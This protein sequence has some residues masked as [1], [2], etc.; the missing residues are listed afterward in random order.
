M[1][2]FF[3]LQVNGYGGVDF[4]DDRLTAEQLHIACARLKDDGVSGILATIVTD[5]GETMARRL[6]NL[7]KL[8]AQDALARQIIAGVHIE[9]PFL[10]EQ[11]GFRG[12]HP[13]DSIHPASED[14]MNRLLDAADGLTRLVTLAP[15]RD[16]A[17]KVTRLLANQG[18]VVSAGHCDAT[19][20]QLRAAIDAGLRMFTH[21]G[22]GCP[23]QLP[24]HDNII[25]RALSLADELWLCFIA[26]GVHVPFFALRN[27]LRAASLEKCVV[28]TDAVAPAGLGLGRYTFGRWQLDIGPDMVARAPDGSHLIGAAITMRQSFDHLVRHVGLSPEQAAALTQTNPRRALGAS[29]RQRG[30]NQ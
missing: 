27:Y 11:P 14:E 12:A 29:A 30:A 25:Q 13:A 23:M 15:E 17:L 10:N 5:E 2:D 28:V 24:R 3:D 18:I 21:L 26:D 20:D 7:A 8:R 1:S 19:L 16:A 4:N 9:G 6:A 22:N